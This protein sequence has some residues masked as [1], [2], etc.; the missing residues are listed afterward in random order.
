MNRSRGRRARIAE[1]GR[2]AR[3]TAVAATALFTLALPLA[4]TAR[5]DSSGSSAPLPDGPIESSLSV[6]ATGA[7]AATG[8]V[9]I[10]RRH[11]RRSRSRRR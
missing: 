4:G 7:V 2:R 1:P 3:M 8:A 5:A 6:I 9:L 10:V 11:E